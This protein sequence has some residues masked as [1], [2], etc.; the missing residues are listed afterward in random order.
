MPKQRCVPTGGFYVSDNGRLPARAAYDTYLTPPGNVAVAF[1]FL[2]EHEPLLESPFSPRILD[3]GA[4]EGVW[5]QVA[6]EYWPAAFIHGVELRALPKPADYNIWSN[7]DMRSWS[8]NYDCK[9]FDLV[10][11]NP[12]YSLAE[13]AVRIGLQHVCPGGMVMLL[14]PL[15]FLASQS[16]RDGLYREYPLTY[17]AQFSQRI[18]WTGNGKTPPRDHALFCWRKGRL[19]LLDRKPFHGYFLPNKEK[20]NDPDDK[21]RNPG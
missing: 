16:R 8:N 5:G 13:E 20:F 10:V 19:P 4:G 17:F 3:L 1:D 18:S 6:R 7:V 2:V 14:L 11:G 9:P 21:T 15:T 12:P